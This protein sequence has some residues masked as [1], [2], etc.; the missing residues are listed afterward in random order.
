MKIIS[1]DKYNIAWF[2]LAECISRGEKERALGVYRLLSHSIKDKAL[3]SQ[4]E[5]DIFLLFDTI[6]QAEKCYYDAAQLYKQDGRVLEAAAIY[7]HL[8]TLFP[9]N[10]GYRRQIVDLYAQQNILSKVTYHT[11]QLI[12]SAL[13]TNQCNQAIEYAQKLEEKGN[14]ESCTLAFQ[15]LT[16]G[17]IEAKDIDQ[18]VVA[19]SLHKT[20]DYVLINEND[21][22]LQQFLAKVRAIDSRW[23]Q[24]ASEHL[25]R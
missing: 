20:I 21:G 3:V 7:E 18:D 17:L 9:K 8:L 22:Q 24:K 25:K 19:E 13:Q 15:K 12:D 1:A 14:T 11:L 5:G 4:L 16:L 23:Y 2:K 10:Q 6:D